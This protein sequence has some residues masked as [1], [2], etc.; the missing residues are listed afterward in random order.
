MKAAT[1][2]AARILLIP[3][4]L[5]G[6]GCGAEGPDVA[7][8]P[9]SEAREALDPACSNNEF[10]VPGSI[11]EPTRL[12]S[13]STHFCWLSRIHYHDNPK[14]FIDQDDGYWYVEEGKESQIRCVPKSCFRGDGV[15]DVVWISTHNISAKANCKGDC[16][17]TVNHTAWW[18]DAATVLTAFEGPG[19]DVD[20]AYVNGIGE[21]VQVIQSNSATT[22]S[23]IQAA[24]CHSEHGFFT[25]APDVGITGRAVSLFVGTPNSGRLAKFTGAEF[26]VT[27]NSTMSLGVFTDEAIC[28]FTKFYGAGAARLFQVADGSRNVWTVKTARIDSDRGVRAVGRC[29]W[30]HQSD[31]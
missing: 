3:L 28:Y 11:A 1:K 7:L 17:N 15:D 20:Q 19:A 12:K 4:A 24:D 5:T 22:S 18:G 8:E 30:F 16:A 6:T 14:V 2:R 23:G 29:F 13:S 25:G 27:G 26:S 9:T 31:K 10:F 21:N